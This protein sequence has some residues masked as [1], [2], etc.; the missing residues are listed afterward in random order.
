[1]L[2]YYA[3]QQP[4]VV[5]RR[6]T[7]NHLLQFQPFRLNPNY[8][9]KNNTQLTEQVAIQVSFDLFKRLKNRKRRMRVGEYLHKINQSHINEFIKAQLL[10]SD[11]TSAMQ[12][13][14]TFFEFNEID[15]DDYSLESAYKSWQRYK[16]DFLEKNQ[17]NNFRFWRKTVLGNT[18]KTEVTNEQII[19]FDFILVS[20][21]HFFKVGYTNLLLKSLKVKHR[22]TFFKYHFDRVASR[23]FCYER[24]VLYYLLYHHAG[25]NSI[26]IAA[27][28]NVTPRHVRFSVCKIRQEKEIYDNVSFDIDCLEHR[29]LK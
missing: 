1:M 16:K 5:N 17:K 13:L 18:A 3:G 29:L 6:D 2:K 25:M 9:K 19:S 11:R 15:E 4:F 28:T 14:K 26:E 20:V 22:N 21:N 7:Y 12:A 24:Q 23:Q 10:E 27:L 8:V